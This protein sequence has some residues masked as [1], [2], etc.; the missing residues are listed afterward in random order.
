MPATLE[1][2]DYIVGGVTGSIFSLLDMLAIKSQM[3]YLPLQAKKDAWLQ[4]Q[5]EKDKMGETGERIEMLTTENKQNEKKCKDLEDR[6]SMLESK[7]S[8][9]TFPKELPGHLECYVE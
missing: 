8:I 2:L 9:H 7:Y 5:A 4:V 3:R 1:K 6:L